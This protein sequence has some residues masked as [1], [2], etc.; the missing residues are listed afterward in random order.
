[1]L[2]HSSQIVE[3]SL[4]NT[5]TESVHLGF[6]QDSLLLHVN[7]TTMTSRRPH[8]SSQIIEAVPAILETKPVTLWAEAGQKLSYVH[9]KAA[10]S[11]YDCDP[12]VNQ[13]HMNVMPTLSDSCA[14]M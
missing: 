12:D 3:T 11:A 2:H 7:A 5:Q 6:E 9:T 4:S 8:R 1:M 10:T 14:G 13:E